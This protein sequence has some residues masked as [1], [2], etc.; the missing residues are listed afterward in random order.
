MF[1]A[2]DQLAERHVIAGA[3]PLDER[4]SVEVGHSPILLEP[5]PV[6]FVSAATLKQFPTRAG[7]MVLIAAGSTALSVVIVGGARR[8]KE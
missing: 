3:T 4:W 7:L 6:R 5:E 2:L 1:I 8:L